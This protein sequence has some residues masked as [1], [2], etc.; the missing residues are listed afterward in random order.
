MMLALI[1]FEAGGGGMMPELGLKIGGPGI[2]PT[3]LEVLGKSDS[4]VGIWDV[5]E[6]NA[7]PKIVTERD[8]DRKG[9]ILTFGPVAQEYSDLETLLLV[10]YFAKSMKTDDGRKDVG[11][12]LVKYLESMEK[13]ITSMQKAAAGNVM[14]A[15]INQY[16]C[17]NI[18]ARMGLITSYDQIQTKTWL[19]HVYGEML[20]KDYAMAA[21][22]GITT[23][24]DATSTST[25]TTKEGTTEKDRYAGLATLAKVLSKE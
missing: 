3:I 22:Q 2:V 20:K 15:L 24:V 4:S 10:V 8:L 25:S 12:I 19:D 6:E 11:L 21:V 9:N 13:V 18:Y 17:T 5:F 23:M 7:A 1:F 16:A 14:T